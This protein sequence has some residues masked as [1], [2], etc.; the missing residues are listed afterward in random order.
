LLLPV[1]LLA[2]RVPSLAQPAGADQGLYAYVGQRILAGDIAYRDAWDQKPPAVHYAYAAML[3]IWPSAGVVAGADLVVAAATAVCLGVI[4]SRLVAHPVAGLLTASLYLLFANPAFTRL[5]GVR[6]RAQ[7]ETFIGLCIAMAVLTISQRL[8][9]RASVGPGA[10]A[11][12]GVFVGLAATFKYNAVVYA[13]P[14]GVAILVAAFEQHG[15]WRGAIRRSAAPLAAAAAGLAA[16]VVFMVA[17]FWSAGALEDFYLATITYNLRYSGETYASRWHMVQYLLTFPVG[18][19]RLDAL[20]LLG[21][22]GSAVLLAV[23]WWQPRAAIVVAWVAA[24]CLAIAING[25]RALP[26]YFVQAWPPLALAAGVAAG[27]VVPALRRRGR[28]ALA[29]ALVLAVPRVTQFQKMIETTAVDARRLAGLIDTDTYLG[30]FGR[31]DS[32]DKFAALAV[33]RLAQHLETTTRADDPVFVF[34]FSPWGYVGS[35]RESSSRFFWSRPVIIGFEADRP[36]YGVSGLLDDLRRRPPA[37][38]VLQ[39]RDWDP[40]GPN[41]LDFFL[42]DPSLVEWLNASYRPAGTLHNFHLW[43]RTDRQ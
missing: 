38:V 39:A 3:A 30:R 37:V 32:G 9:R 36:R 15:T 6:I 20:W 29:V 7:C 25:S 5:G 40:D 21:G 8:A 41:S 31:I 19:A 13:L 26:Q 14:L 1:L 24:A 4:A 34:G 17:A 33:H 27:L 16:P 23:S 12:A 35:G 18:H 42:A 2:L 22:A 28:I 43:T 11:L 10:A